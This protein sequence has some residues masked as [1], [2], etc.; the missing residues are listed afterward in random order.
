MISTGIVQ[1]KSIE[2]NTHQNF[3]VTHFLQHENYFLRYNLLNCFNIIVRMAALRRF[4]WTA[5]KYGNEKYL[6]VEDCG[7]ETS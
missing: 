7:S 3:Y 2:V 6:D 1:F 4:V 5:N